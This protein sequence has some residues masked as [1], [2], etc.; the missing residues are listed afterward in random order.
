MNFAFRKK[1][2]EYSLLTCL[3]GTYQQFGTFF[4]HLLAQYSWHHVMFLYNAHPPSSGRG[5]SMCEFTLGQAFTMLGGQKNENISHIPFDAE[6]SNRSTYN[7]LLQKASSRSRIIAMCAPTSVVRD[8]LLTADDM[9]MLS[10][11]EYVFFNIDLF[12]TN[13]KLIRPWINDT[14]TSEEN[15]R[16]RRAFEYVLTVSASV[17]NNESFSGFRMKVENVSRTHLNNSAEILVNS[18]VASFYDALIAYGNAFANIMLSENITLKEQIKGGQIVSHIWD[19]THQ[20][21][22]NMTIDSNGDK[23]T[24]FSLLDLNTERGIF[25]VVQVYH[26]VT[27]SFESV[28][29]IDWPYRAGPPPDVPECGFDGQLCDTGGRQ[30]VIVF[31]CL[32]LSLLVIMLVASLL[33]F[34]YYKREA[35]IASMNWKIDM[36]E[37]RF[38]NKHRR[39]SLT[40]MSLLLSGS[41]S[42]LNSRET[43]Y[44]ENKQMYMTTGYYKGS[45]VALKKIQADNISM[46]RQLLIELKQM[47]DL[48]HDH[49]VRF[50]GACLDHSNPLLVTE[51]C[52]RGSLQDILEEE[53][54]DLDWNFKYS[55]INDIVKGLSFIH[56]SDINLHGNLK[57]SNCVVDSRFVLKLTDFGLHGLRGSAE[58]DPTSYEYFKSKLWTS[59]EILHKENK[60]I[61]GTQKGDMYAFAII[62][63]EIVERQ[64]PWGVNTSCLEPQNI[65]EKVTAGGFRPT[66]DKVA[67][68]EELSSMMMKCWAEDPRERPDIG[69]VRSVVKKINKD[70]NSSNI[71]DNLL[72][73]ME[74]YANNLEAVVE[75]RTQ[76]YLEEKKKCENLLHELLPP[77]VASKLVQKQTVNAESFSSVTI[78]FSDIV[79]F[80]NLSSASTPME[81]VT[82]LNDLYTCFDSIIQ[83]YDVYKVE[84]IG[85]AYMVVSGL[86][87]QN[88]DNHAREIA[89]MSLNILQKV[90]KFKI[91]HR[92]EEQLKIRIGLHTGPCVAGVVGIKM[93]RYCLFGD[94]VNTAS[95]ME[96]N[97]EPFKIHMSSSTAKLLQTFLTFLIEERG[98]LEI[99]GKGKMVTYWLLGE[100]EMETINPD[101]ETEASSDR[102]GNKNIKPE[103]VSARAELRNLARKD[104]NNIRPRPASY[105]TQDEK[106]PLNSRFGHSERGKTSFLKM[107][108]TVIIT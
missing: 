101:D 103:F 47:K 3:G 43:M 94:T 65:I 23:R 55:L 19:K 20:G 24:D 5:M 14:A 69:F 86:P 98:E 2:S 54:M 91:R 11:G 57:S 9:D 7:E 18:F 27:N 89:R 25:E 53:E 71:L 38:G 12:S 58:L 84:T 88:G 96:S 105:S 59:P 48:Q 102:D 50:V 51:Y 22:E 61:S 77:S 4:Q 30:L 10:S 46:N 100:K 87:L 40:R 85:D 82:L 75:E 37:I 108:E 29:D 74:Q 17:S 104:N 60:Y 92:P 42:S 73:R 68:D 13:S 80:T 79:G 62:L 44:G 93:P 63:H 6:N 15:E 67:M 83:Y 97:G 39:A 8:I 72:S 76:S 56:S 66:V 45:R 16:A 32:S 70:N 1:T 31:L 35:D 33:I 90:G 95:R 49:L 99:K 26:G 78:Y 64:G 36:D 41:Q 52:P 107:K 21:V 34:R 106:T 81:I 28:G